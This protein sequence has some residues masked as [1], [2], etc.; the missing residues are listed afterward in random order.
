[1]L[2][3]QGPEAH[4]YIFMWCECTVKG[5]FTNVYRGS[6]SDSSMT[7]KTYKSTDWSSIHDNDTAYCTCQSVGTHSEVKGKKTQIILI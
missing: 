1:M 2:N 5:S 6:H 4:I 3:K 7:Q